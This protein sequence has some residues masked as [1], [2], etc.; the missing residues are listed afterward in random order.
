MG[1]RE[2]EG[3]FLHLEDGTP[4]IFIAMNNMWGGNN[5]KMPANVGIKIAENNPTNLRL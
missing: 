5:Q 3:V 1:E 4:A 2:Y